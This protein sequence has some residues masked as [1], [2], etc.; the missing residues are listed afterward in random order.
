[1]TTTVFKGKRSALDLFPSSMK[2][3]PVQAD[4][5]EKIEAAFEAGNKFVL[6]EAPTGCHAKGQ[7][8]ILSDGRV[9]CVE[10]IMVGDRLLSGTPSLDIYPERRGTYQTVTALAR[11]RGEM[12]R[13]VPV[14]GEP[15]TVNLGHILTLKRTSQNP[16]GRKH[17]EDCVDGEVIDVSV[18]D[19]MTWS[20]TRKHLYKL[21]KPEAVEFEP[22]AE[23]E[24]GGEHADDR[25]LLISPYFLGVLLGDGNVIQTVRVTSVD[26]EVQQACY[27]EA[28]KWG[29]KVVTH[30]ITHTL[31]AGRNGSK[32][33]P[34]MRELERLGVRGHRAESKFVPG[35]YRR[36]PLHDRLELLAGLM[37]TDGSLVNNCF[38]F[39][40]KSK[41]LA[42][43]VVWLAR[44][45]GLAASARPC[46]K[47]CQT[48]AGGVYHRV[49]LSGHT[50]I[51]PCRIARKKAERRL[52]KK[53]ALMTGFQIEPCGVDD[54]FGFSL[55]G[56][57]RFLLGDFTVTHNTGKSAIAMALARRYRSAYVATLTKN[58]QDQY[59]NDPA[60]KDYD[61]AP[62]KGKGAYRCTAL[63]KKG[64]CHQ[65][66]IY[67]NGKCPSGEDCPYQVAKREALKS[68]V[69]VANYHSIIYNELPT[70][71]LL[72]LDEGHD[73]EDVLL[74]YVSL[75]IRLDK[76]PAGTAPLPRNPEGL[77]AWWS[78]LVVLKDALN[79]KAYTTGD[80]N[81]RAELGERVERIERVISAKS[82]AEWIVD[83]DGD[84]KGFKLQPVTA[85]PFG[86]I[87]FGTGERVLLMS[88]T[89]LNP[90]AL[91]E[92]VGIDGRVAE[93]VSEPCMFPAEN[94]PIRVFDLDMRFDARDESW[95]AMVGIVGDI[96]RFHQKDKGLIL[97][98]S[99]AL[100][101]Y[102][103]VNLEQQDR[104][105]AARLILASGEE[106]QAAYEGHLRSKTATVLCAPGMWEGIDL[107]DDLSRFQIICGLPRPY[108]GSA[109]VRARAKL[110]YWWYEWKT[111]A[112]TVQGL[113]R[114]VR[115]ERD[116]AT[117]YVLD[118]A[119][120][121]HMQRTRDNLIPQWMRDAVLEE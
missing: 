34:L 108:W 36:A 70:R 103:K 64:S 87:L 16:R 24:I 29:L 46:E 71:P 20:N 97:A 35:E 72:V 4:A 6:L 14:K 8:I 73:I 92:S 48:G 74:D 41:R 121:V 116:S 15:F 104:V 94:R 112:K 30:G 55:D 110:H 43:D 77:E 39:V 83:L 98:P 100:L 45:V 1:M 27:T 40:S 62:L 53:N 17:R 120:R 19:W 22:Y 80:T 11:G 113:G 67:Y 117:S 66:A 89:I 5:L 85:A 75:A 9:K 118:R 12:V 111:M 21:F 82:R 88:A 52:Q 90:S 95:A 78:W 58:L 101:D 109:R 32:A 18:R 61:L 10:D 105:T 42:S 86:N 59:L 54:Y 76:L 23:Q 63:R 81:E 31:S 79:V 107:R 26:L 60:F 51:L 84:K 37:D 119:F 106:R 68:S 99:R 115:S 3:R 49:T 56:N 7:E 33:N 44:S 91:C 28:F 2:I 47:Y 13:V 38:D 57:G 69:C 93:Y 114:S 25:V 50:N 65:G 102:L 96:L